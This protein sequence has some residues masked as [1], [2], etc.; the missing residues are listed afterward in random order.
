M[1]SKNKLPKHPEKLLVRREEV[2]NFMNYMST[3]ENFCLRVWNTVQAVHERAVAEAAKEAED[4][5]EG[6]RSQSVPRPIPTG[7]VGQLSDLDHSPI[8]AEAV[9]A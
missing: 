1:S 2:I 9:P 6:G 5:I 7:E 4:G 3:D 8:L